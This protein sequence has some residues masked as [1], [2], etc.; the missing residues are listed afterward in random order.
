[1]PVGE[2]VEPILAGAGATLDQSSEQAGVAIGA[3]QVAGVEVTFAARLIGALREL[4]VVK[5]RTE[6][7]GHGLR[8]PCAV[9]VSKAVVSKAQSLRQ[10]P[11]L[12]VVLGE[13][14]SDAKFTVTA[15][16]LDSLF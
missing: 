5:P 1:M 7:S 8:D 16:G 3:E 4:P 10:H 9:V 14:R 15:C 13:E 12:P 11:S 2:Q 6:P